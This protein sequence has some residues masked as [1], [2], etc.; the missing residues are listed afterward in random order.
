[1]ITGV[2]YCAVAAPCLLPANSDTVVQD[3][4]HPMKAPLPPKVATRH[5]ERATEED[6]DD[7]DDIDSEGRGKGGPAERGES[8]AHRCGASGTA[9]ERGFGQR[10]CGQLRGAV[11]VTGARERVE[12][13]G[14]YSLQAGSIFG[15]AHLGTADSHYRSLGRNQLVVT[16]RCQTCFP[17]S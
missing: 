1:M 3:A 9:A 13:A 11:A 4:E 16:R 12:A 7:I 8:A 5:L 17:Q 2:L 14:S 10:A 15:D 6:T